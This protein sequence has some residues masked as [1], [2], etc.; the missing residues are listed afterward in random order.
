MVS[1]HAQHIAMWCQ[2]IHCRIFVEPLWFLC[3]FG[4]NC[5]WFWSS[6]CWAQWWVLGKRSASWAIWYSHNLGM[7]GIEIP[8][9]SLSF[10][11]SLSLLD[12]Y[13]EWMHF[14]WCLKD[15]KTCSFEMSSCGST[16]TQCRWFLKTRF[17]VLLL[18]MTKAKWWW[19]R[20]PFGQHFQNEILAISCELKLWT[21]FGVPFDYS[22][23][24]IWNLRMMHM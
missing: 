13:E 12:E 16:K 17:E 9:L 19:W 1:Y 5:L 18:G 23:A 2:L 20:W 6:L 11:M 22:R 4:W 24:H 21:G 10:N 3:A 15:P 14:W 8:E 7:H